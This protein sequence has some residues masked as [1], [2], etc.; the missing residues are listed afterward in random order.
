MTPETEFNAELY[1]RIWKRPRGLSEDC[2]FLLFSF[3]PLL[4][5]FLEV[6]IELFKTRFPKERATNAKITCATLINF[7][8]TSVRNF[9]M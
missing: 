3:L 1:A 9:E 4:L 5:Y 2:Y 8:F 7:A 6:F